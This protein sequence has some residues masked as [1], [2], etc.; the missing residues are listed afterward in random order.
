MPNDPRA[1]RKAQAIKDALLKRDDI[2]KKKSSFEG[3]E[4]AVNPRSL[5]VVYKD[6]F[7]QISTNLNKRL[8]DKYGLNNV[9]VSVRESLEQVV[10][11]ADGNLHFGVDVVSKKRMTRATS[12]KL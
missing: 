5:P 4:V 8:K 2:V 11:D 3:E 1:D 12:I 7:S 6:T 10:Q 9:N